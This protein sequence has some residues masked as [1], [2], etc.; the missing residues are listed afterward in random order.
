MFKYLWA[1]VPE[2]PTLTTLAAHCQP[3]LWHSNSGF[4]ELDNRI[5]QVLG[6]VDSNCKAVIVFEVSLRGDVLLDNGLLG[7]I[8]V[9]AVHPHSSIIC[10]FFATSP[11]V[12]VELTLVCLCLRTNKLFTTWLSIGATLKVSV[13]LFLAFHL[14]ETYGPLH[15]ADWHIAR[16]TCLSP[17][18]G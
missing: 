5:D 7:F 3:K 13:I 17:E 14:V 16:L 15:V 1:R 8:P 10:A 9:E 6:P 18:G 11:V 2:S 4:F 12:V